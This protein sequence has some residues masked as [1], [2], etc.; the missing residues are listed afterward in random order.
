MNK[1]FWA[2][3]MFQVLYKEIE[4]LS[5]KHSQGGRTEVKLLLMEESVPWVIWANCAWEMITTPLAKDLLRASL[6]EE[7]KKH[8]KKQ[9]AQ[10][11]NSYFIDVKCPSCYKI[12]LVF[13]HAQT[14]VLLCRLFNSI[15]SAYRRKGQTHRRLFF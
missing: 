13:S 12:T 1:Y 7:K 5:S 14:V 11:P 4:S 9:L 10:S 8:K 2:F 15:V 3:T 6:E